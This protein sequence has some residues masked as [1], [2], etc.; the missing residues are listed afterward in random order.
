VPTLGRIFRRQ[1]WRPVE[2]FGCFLPL[3]TEKAEKLGLFFS[4]QLCN[5][6]ALA[7]RDFGVGEEL[8]VQRN[9]FLADKYIEGHHYGSPTAAVSGDYISKVPSGSQA[10]TRGDNFGARKA[11][12]RNF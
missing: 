6:I 3:R 1:R 10:L 7:S 2:A 4:Q 8:L 9:I 5:H 11:N 12:L